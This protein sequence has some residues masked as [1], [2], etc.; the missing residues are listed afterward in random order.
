MAAHQNILL[1][2]CSLGELQMARELILAGADPNTKVG[3]NNWTCLMVAILGSQEEVVDLLLAQ[4]GLDVNAKNNNN[5]TALHYTCDEGNIA[6]L[7]KL[8]VVPGILVRGTAMAGLRSCR[9]Q[10]LRLF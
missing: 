2:M 8:L 5:S 1:A 3:R 9:Q 6:I 4:P 10:S 7:S